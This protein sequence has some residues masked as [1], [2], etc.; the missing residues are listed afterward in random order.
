MLEVG[1]LNERDSGASEIKDG[2]RDRSGLN[3]L[4]EVTA[5]IWI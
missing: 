1:V 2:V 3:I 5:V 4:K